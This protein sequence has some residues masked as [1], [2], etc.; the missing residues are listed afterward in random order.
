MKIRMGFVSNSSSSSFCI[1][2]AMFDDGEVDFEVEK[3]E[4]EEEV[5]EDED[6][7]LWEERASKLGLEHH[8]MGSDDIHYIGIS[9]SNIKDNETG[10]QF[11]KR[12]EKLVAEFCG[13]K[14]KCDV[15]EEAFYDG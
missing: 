1:Y 2:G 11:K 8:S 10:K 13:K 9:Y 12:V 14:T 5:E 3:K 4:G 15:Y 7:E 6:Y